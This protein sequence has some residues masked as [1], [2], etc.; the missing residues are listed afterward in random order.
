[1]T[2][3]LK[4][5]I[6]SIDNE[7]TII[8][9][10]PAND[11]RLP[12]GLSL[13]SIGPPQP[14]DVGYDTDWMNQRF[15]LIKMGSK[16]LVLQT[17]TTGPLRDRISFWSL[18]AFEAWAANTVTEIAMPNGKIRTVTWAKRWMKDPRRRFYYG[19]IFRPHHWGE[20]EQDPEDY[21]NV[22]RGFGVKPE[23][24]KGS[25]KIFRDHLL[26]NVC[27]G[28]EHL[29]RYLIAWMAQMVQKPRE[30]VGVALV[31]RGG[32]G[33]GKTKVGEV[34][35]KLLPSHYI[36]VDDPRYV[37]GQFNSHM[38][39]CV[40]LQADEA[41][42]AGD[43]TAEGRLK[44]LITASTQ[45]I[46]NKGLD[47]IQSENYIR[48]LMTSNEGWVVPASFDE[49][50]YAVFDVNG[51]CAQNSQYFKEMDEE[52]GMGGYEALLYDLL[53]FDLSIVDL[54]QIPKTKALLDQKLRSMDSLK[55]WWFERLKAGTP[56]RKEQEWVSEVTRE[57][58]FEDYA[59]AAEL[60]GWRRRAPQTELGMTLRKLMPTL[61]G[62]RH[63][64]P[65]GEAESVRTA[66]RR[67]YI[68]PPLAVARA[69]FEQAIG[70]TIDWE[71]PD[72]NPDESEGVAR[73]E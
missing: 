35:G 65:V 34:L 55:T 9:D 48:V 7:G 16:L 37:V 12:P 72:D 1:M 52:L 8:G 57:A 19:I 11:D 56:T 5:I 38:F 58:L 22:W 32:M 47:P 43:K 73:T 61:K 28:K 49:R 63:Q 71:D 21:L 36:L 14:R 18:D 42:W 29:L 62:S 4:S 39:A 15:A 31:L 40:L 60:I 27:D 30:R 20:V 3:P 53:H 46:E 66:R 26:I 70:Q 54:R 44:G 67:T 64:Y 2:D 6:P 68:L 13:T 17:K 25:W 50:R 69:S 45:M 59:E 33:S 10:D 41:V 51:Q 23:K 24:D